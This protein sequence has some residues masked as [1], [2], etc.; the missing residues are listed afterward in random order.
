MARKEAAA[1]CYRRTPDGVQFILVNRTAKFTAELGH[2]I[3]A[4]DLVLEKRVFIGHGRSPLWNELKD[5][6]VGS[7]GLPFWS[8]EASLMR[9]RPSRPAP[10]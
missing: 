2:A 9:P 10:E 1:V 7:L 6:V 4:A 5:F 8:T 3:R